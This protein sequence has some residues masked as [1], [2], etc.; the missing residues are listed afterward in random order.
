[1][2]RRRNAGTAGVTNRVH[3]NQTD[4]QMQY[5]R[6]CKVRA[7]HARLAEERLGRDVLDRRGRR[8]AAQYTHVP[9]VFFRRFRDRVHGRR[10]GRLA[11][12]HQFVHPT[13]CTYFSDE[14]S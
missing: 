6:D 7:W 8:A 12:G 9:R 5:A 11:G 4:W 2:V 10:F 13:G 1:M 14:T 3:L